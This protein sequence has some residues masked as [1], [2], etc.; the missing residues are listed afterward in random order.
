MVQ[1]QLTQTEKE[2]I[3]ARTAAHLST[4]RRL[5]R[6]S[7]AKF[8][9]LAGIS[10]ARIIQVENNTAPLSWG[11]MTSVLFLAL[12]NARAKEYLYQNNVPGPRFL[13]Y[14]Q[15]KDSNIPPQTN[16]MVHEELVSLYREKAALQ[17]TTGKAVQFTKEERLAFCEYFLPYIGSLRRVMQMSQA[18]LADLAGISRARLIQLEKQKVRLSWSQ[19]TSILCVCMMNLRA[20]EYLYANAILPPRFLQYIQQKNG[21]ELPTLNIRVPDKLIL[22]YAEMM[23]LL[24]EENA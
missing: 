8:G 17:L 14:M 18:T 20:K 3:C 9:E 10:R 24:A 7:Q 13:Q 21:N 12:S 23:K 2:A 11:Q 19:M 22:S 1:V 15:E 16:L 4:L 6:L 5:L